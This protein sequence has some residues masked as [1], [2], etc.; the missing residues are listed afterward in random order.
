M[1]LRHFFVMVS[2]LALIAVVGS[3]ASAQSK[4]KKSTKKT[5]AVAKTTESKPEPAKPQERVPEPIAKRNSRPAEEASQQTQSLPLQTQAKP[6]PL[7]TYEFTQPDFLTSRILIEHDEKGK[8]A[9]AFQRRGNSETFTEPIIVSDAVL[10]KLNAAFTQLNFLDSTENYQHEKDFSHMGNAK[11]SL[12][13]G[14]RS[15]S[16]TLNYTLNKNAKLLM[17][18]YRKI[19]NQALWIFDIT[20]ARENQPLDGPSQMDTLDGLLRR[21]EIADPK[22]LLPFLRELS[23]DERLPLMAR[24]HATRL[25]QQLEKAKK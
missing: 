4:K 25:I 9:M 12:T 3:T 21:S 24:N 18:E 17:D 11:I 2:L 5:P 13:R 23:D 15:R 10:A 20:V 8:G 14:A 7:Y 6:D 22:Q 1:F 16:V 19:S